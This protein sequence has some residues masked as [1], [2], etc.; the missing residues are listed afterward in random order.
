MAKDKAARRD[1]AVI[2]REKANVNV[3]KAVLY[4]GKV[5]GLAKYNPTQDQRLQIVNALRTAFDKME[6]ALTVPPVTAT[7]KETGFNLD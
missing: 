2:L 3:P 4:L 1:K 6:E 5:A 7:P